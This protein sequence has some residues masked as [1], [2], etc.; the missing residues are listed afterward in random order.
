[1]G[2]L[3]ENLSRWEFECSCGCKEDTVDFELIHV[4]QWLRTATGEAVAITSG[5]RCYQWNRVP[6]SEGGPGSND[7]S[8][9]PRG[10]AADIQVENY[11][12]E[13]VYDEL[14]E[15]FGDSISLGLYETF[16]HV[17]TRT[18]GGARWG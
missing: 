15:K 10:R 17:D 11:T 14:D 3:S 4:L 2:D 5:N 6:S 9:H 7:Y 13:M 12:P 16:V 1:M 18:K 8:Q